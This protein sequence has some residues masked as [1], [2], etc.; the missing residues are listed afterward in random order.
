[1]L[2]TRQRKGL[3]QGSEFNY[4]RDAL[5]EDKKKVKFKFNKTPEYRILFAN[6]AYGGVTPRGNFLLH[7]FNEYSPVPTSEVIVL[8]DKGEVKQAQAIRE[9]GESEFG[10]PVYVRDLVVGISMP[11]DQAVSVANFILERVKMAKDRIEEAK[12]SQ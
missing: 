9:Q 2:I 8:G 3:K 6:G 10:K 12:R 4:R 11:A 1:M 7:F 5:A